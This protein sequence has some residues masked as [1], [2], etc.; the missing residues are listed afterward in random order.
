MSA[1]FFLL[2][3]GSEFAL[4]AGERALDRLARGGGFVPPG[5]VQLLNRRQPAADRRSSRAARS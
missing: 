4:D 3:R 2:G 5:L 1:G